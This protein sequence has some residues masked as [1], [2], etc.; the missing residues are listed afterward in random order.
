MCCGVAWRRWSNACGILA[1][2]CSMKSFIKRKCTSQ[3]MCKFLQILLTKFLQL[4]HA[5]HSNAQTLQYSLA[6]RSYSQKSFIPETGRIYT[7]P[8]SFQFLQKAQIFPF[9]PFMPTLTILFFIFIIEI[10]VYRDGFCPF[11][12][13]FGVRHIKPRQIIFE[14]ISHW[15][16][17]NIS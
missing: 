3:Y 16:I 7:F 15:S 4:R 6:P 5:S 8:A 13:I 2:F 1:G 10:P 14:F 12:V 9:S 17:G 11:T